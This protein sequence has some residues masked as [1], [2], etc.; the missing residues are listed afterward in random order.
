MK[1]KRFSVLLVIMLILS[2]FTALLSLQRQN[3]QQ[4]PSLTLLPWEILLLLAIHHL[5]Q[6]DSLI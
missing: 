3:K 6:R 1:L 4:N 5:Q 2:T